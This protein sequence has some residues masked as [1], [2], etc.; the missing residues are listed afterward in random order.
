MNSLVVLNN[1][2]VELFYNQEGLCNKYKDLMVG[3]TK[4]YFSV[5]HN[6][7][8]NSFHAIKTIVRRFYPEVDEK[9]LLELYQHK[10]IRED[11]LKYV[12]YTYQILNV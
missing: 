5:F 8:F 10:V 7:G 3:M 9:E 6:W 12:V 1:E 2:S 11:V 4:I